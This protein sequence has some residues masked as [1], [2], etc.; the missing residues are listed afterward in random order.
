MDPIAQAEEERRFKQEAELRELNDTL[1]LDD[2][3]FSSRDLAFKGKDVLPMGKHRKQI[4]QMAL[5]LRFNS[6]SN[7]RKN[8]MSMEN[9]YG[10]MGGNVDVEEE[11]PEIDL[12]AKPRVFIGSGPI[13]KKEPGLLFFFLS[14]LLAYFFD[15]LFVLFLR[16]ILFWGFLFFLLIS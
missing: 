3:Y 12:N 5:T 2:R 13:S 8:S 1:M 14:R 15:F 11:M 16:I 10:G 6:V 9:I 4:Q 7:R